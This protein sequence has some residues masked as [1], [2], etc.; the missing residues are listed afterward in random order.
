MT[1]EQIEQMIGSLDNSI[2]YLEAMREKLFFE[3]DKLKED[4]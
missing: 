3:L 4:E 1:I 2:E